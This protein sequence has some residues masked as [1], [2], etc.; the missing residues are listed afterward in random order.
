MSSHDMKNPTGGVSMGHV[1]EPPDPNSNPLR[2]FG[3]IFT[4]RLRPDKL[5]ETPSADP[6]AGCCGEGERET[7]PYPIRL[8][9]VTVCM[10]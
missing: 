2:N 9:S 3:L 5:C 4:I 10:K 1:I 7:P 8:L 6:H